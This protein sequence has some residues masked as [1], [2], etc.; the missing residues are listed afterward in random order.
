MN[1]EV[2]EVIYMLMDFL[3]SMGRTSKNNNLIK[4]DE[5]KFKEVKKEL[6]SIINYND[7][8]NDN[9]INYINNINYTVKGKN[10][11][12]K[13]REL[14]GSLPTALID[15]KLF[16]KN[17]DV[18]RLLE[19]SLNFTIERWNKIKRE[20]IIG[21]VISEI[22][23][24]DDN[25]INLF[26]NAWNDFEKGKVFDSVKNEDENELNNTKS[27]DFVDVWLEFFDN[28]KGEKR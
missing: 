12:S 23:K 3:D 6:F 7:N 1:P 20:E 16:P 5:N 27:K 19:K 13:K 22:A 2:K 24:R 4:I 25:E 11:N 14:I 9:Y 21:H 10:E 15:K 28:Y 18:A 26:Y 17:E 8:Y